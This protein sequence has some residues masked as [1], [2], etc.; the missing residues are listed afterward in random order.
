MAEGCKRKQTSN[1]KDIDSLMADLNQ[2]V[3][4]SSVDQRKV[5]LGREIRNGCIESFGNRHKVEDRVDMVVF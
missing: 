2:S 3:A 4:K 5:Y 1:N